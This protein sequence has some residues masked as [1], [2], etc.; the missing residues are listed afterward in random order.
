[1][2]NF[3]SDDFFLLFYNSRRDLKNSYC[4]NLVYIY[5]DI[6]ICMRKIANED[7]WAVGDELTKVVNAIFF[8][9]MNCELLDCS[10]YLNLHINN[11]SYMDLL[12][13]SKR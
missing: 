5:V 11:I 7:T 6:S 13:K 10:I 1:M 4:Y 9:A 3:Y 8:V 12:M 2:K